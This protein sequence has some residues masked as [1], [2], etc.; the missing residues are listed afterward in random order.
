[1]T[2]VHVTDAQILQPPADL[3]DELTELQEVGLIW[4]EMIVCATY[5]G[6]ASAL[7]DLVLE[8]GRGT[9]AD[10]AELAVRVEAAVA[11]TEGMARRLMD[12]D[13]D[14]D[15]LA[16]SLVT[17]FTVQDLIRASVGQ[18]VE[19]LGGMAFVSSSDVAYLSAAAQ[20]IAFHPPS[21]TSMI[22]G[23]LDY[24]SGEPLVVS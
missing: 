20:A 7:V 9:S 11:L 13:T 5:T 12:G 4:F 8:R 18:A 16:A 24:Y 2:D 19:L 10:R 15:G 3:A 22:D 1:L 21:R 14:N 23:L 17:R 6:I